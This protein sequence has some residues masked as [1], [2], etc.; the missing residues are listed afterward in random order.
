MF[1]FVY[2]NYYR[3]TTKQTYQKKE[4]Q[5]RLQR[6]SRSTMVHALKIVLKI[7]GKI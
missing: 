4:I 1:L 3:S 5:K 2:N 6:N 7:T